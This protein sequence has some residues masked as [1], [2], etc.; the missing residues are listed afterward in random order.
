MYS[1]SVSYDH[2]QE[3]RRPKATNHQPFPC[4]TP[5]PRLYS[6]TNK[7]TSPRPSKLPSTPALYST[8]HFPEPFLGFLWP[9]NKAALVATWKTSLTP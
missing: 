8:T 1:Y 5:T 6:H 2:P 4:D 9:T 3:K 7:T